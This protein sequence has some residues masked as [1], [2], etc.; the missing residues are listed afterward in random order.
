[1]K[2]QAS[3]EFLVIIAALTLMMLPVL[4]IMNLN[5]QYSQERMALSKATFSAARLAAA[6][7]SVGAMGLGAKLYTTVELP[8]TESIDVQGHAIAIRLRTSYGPVV[9]V[10]A[11]RFNLNA[12]GIERASSPGTYTF[13]VTGPDR[14]SPASHVELLLR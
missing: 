14:V 4:V 1:M 2:G 11:S 13:E 6:A 8:A 12:T 7:D 5:V 9:I 3:S 10:Q